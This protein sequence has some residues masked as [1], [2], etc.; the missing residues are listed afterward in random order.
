MSRSMTAAGAN[1]APTPQRRKR[2]A[3]PDS[4]GAPMSAPPTPTLIEA[5]RVYA[6]IGLLSF[7]GPAG[8]LALMPRELVDE[9]R[10][11]DG[12]AFLPPLTF[13]PLLPGPEAQQP[14][15]R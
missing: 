1:G 15:H 14:P 11:I 13:C 3:Q 8:Q 5:I 12:P 9:R 10:W 6:R 4:P 2:P 7:G